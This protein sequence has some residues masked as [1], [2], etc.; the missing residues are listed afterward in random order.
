MTP[1]VYVGFGFGAIQ[2]GL[3][4]DEAFRSGRFTRL[5]V[6]EVVESA[7]QTVRADQGTFTVNVAGRAGIERHV[8]KGIEIYNPNRAEDR[9]ALVEAIGQASELSTALPSVKFFESGGAASVAGVLADGLRRKLADPA[10][11][12]AVVY[13]AENNNHAA[14]ILHD[15]LA[16]QLGPDMARAD[17]RCQLLNTV[18]GKMSGVVTDPGQIRDQDLAPAG[19][20]AGRAFLVEAFNR[21]L[22]TRITLPGFERGIG[23]FEEKD[24]LL[25]FEEAKLYGH[26]ATHALIGY[27]GSLRGYAT[28]AEAGTDPTILSIARLA[29]MGE[30]G[31]ALQAKYKGLDPLFTPAGWTAYTEDLLERMANPNLRD[32]VDRIIRDPRRKLGWTDRLIGAMRLAREFGIQA[33]GYAYGAAAAVRLLKLE[34]S[35]PFPALLDAVWKEAHPN[36]AEA[37]AMLALIEEADEKLDDL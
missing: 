22:I 26:N 7:V 13:T 10:L 15:C 19:T 11:P 32:A 8:V 25:P 29:F 30:S 36:P 21:I 20:G 3:F 27:L 35:L 6:A 14:E 9:Q 4:L 24:D 34:D 18:I 23:V 2:A 28:M 37:R 31:K 1:R 16:R 5:V 17:S 33:N 12:A